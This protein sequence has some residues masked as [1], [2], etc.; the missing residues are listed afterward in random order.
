MSVDGGVTTLAQRPSTVASPGL[1][2]TAA[3]TAPSRSARRDWL[4]TCATL[5]V[6]KGRPF[7]DSF[8]VCKMTTL[9]G[10]ASRQHFPS[11]FSVVE[12]DP[13][14]DATNQSRHTYVMRLELQFQAKATSLKRR[15]DYR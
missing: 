11:K 15:S 8:L 10:S 2:A 1:R 14:V 5:Q 6:A 3:S 12:L 13:L 9:P 4:F 7:T